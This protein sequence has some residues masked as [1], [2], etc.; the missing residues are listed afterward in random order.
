MSV[1]MDLERQTRV[2]QATKERGTFDQGSGG[3]EDDGM[4]IG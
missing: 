2:V 4:G 3:G 1:G